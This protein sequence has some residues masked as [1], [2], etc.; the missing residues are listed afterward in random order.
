MSYVIG[1]V[2]YFALVIPFASLVGRFL[3]G[4]SDARARYA[5]YKDR[6]NRP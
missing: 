6:A 2:A 3:Q 4:R 5:Y 1:A